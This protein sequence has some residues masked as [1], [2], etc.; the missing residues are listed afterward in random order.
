MKQTGRSVSIRTPD[1]YT[2]AGD[3]VDVEGAD[4]VAIMCHGINSHKLEHLDMF[5]KLAGRLEAVGISSIRFDFRGHGDSSGGS[6][7]FSIVG[8][9]LDLKSAIRWID[10]HYDGKHISKAFVGVSFGAGPG[11]CLSATYQPFSSISLVAPVLSYSRTFLNPETSWAKSSFNESAYEHAREFGYL[12]LDSEF[13]ISIRLL[14]EMRLLHPEVTIGSI[15]EPVLLIH[16]TADTLVPCQVSEEVAA[17][18]RQIEAHI[19]KDMHHGLYVVGDDEGLSEESIAVEDAAL[20]LI[21]SHI[22]RN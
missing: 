5:P 11:I 7:D 10:T 20:N 2:L 14:E 13:K 12:L 21:V 1:G 3:L 16:G 17:K 8:Q 22:G 18:F 4:Q 15:E 19:V 6:E 9:L